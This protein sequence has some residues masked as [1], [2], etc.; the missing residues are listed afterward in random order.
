MTVVARADDT[1]ARDTQGTLSPPVRHPSARAC[2]SAGH[3]CRTALTASSTGGP[4]MK[5]K[6]RPDDVSMLQMNDWL[7]E[8]RDDG[9]AEPPAEGRAE[10]ASGGAWPEAPA[11]PAAPAEPAVPAEPAASAGAAMRA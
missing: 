3:L 4:D 9:G 10:P 1:I 7:A 11:Q 6:I 5:T 2:P 8:L